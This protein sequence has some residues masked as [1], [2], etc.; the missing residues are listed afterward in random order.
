MKPL[1]FWVYK[2][3]MEMNKLKLLIV[4]ALFVL[5]NIVDAQ[6]QSG[7]VLDDDFYGSNRG[8]ASYV[9]YRNSFNN[10]YGSN[11]NTYWPMMAGENRCDLRQDIMIQVSPIGCQPAV[12]R[13]DLLAE[14][15]VP[16][17]CQ[18]DLLQLNPAIDVKQIKSMSFSGKYPPYV[19][20]VGFHPARAALRTRGSL[21]GSPIESN[22]GYVVVILKQNQ[23]ETAL[24]DFFNFT[25]S[26]TIDY[27]S[28]NALG[29]GATELLIEESSEEEWSTKKYSQSFL[30]GRYSVRLINSDPNG[31]RIGLYEGDIKTSELS[32]LRDKGRT[33]NIYLPNSYCQTELK[34]SYDEFTSSG[35]IIKM[36]IDDD[37]LDLYEGARFLNGQCIVRK[38]SKSG[39]NDIAEVSCGREILKL[40]IKMRQLNNGTE[41]YLDNKENKI[42]IIVST[43]T[44]GKTY[45]IRPLEKKDDSKEDKKIDISKITPV[46]KDAIY[47]KDYGDNNEYINGST[48]HYEDVTDTYGFEKGMAHKYNKYY[49]EI[50]LEEAIDLNDKNERKATASK[51]IDKYL[52]QYPEGEQTKNYRD[53]QNKYYMFDSSLSG[54]MIKT[55]DGVVHLVKILDIRDPAKLSSAK[56]VWGGQD[57]NLLLGN[58]APTKYGAI[59]LTSVRNQNNL[60][61]S[62]LCDSNVQDNKLNEPRVYESKMSLNLHEDK[63]V[64]GRNL[65]V[66]SVDLINSINL[67]INAETKTRTTS[68]FTV[69]IGIDKRLFQ[70]TPD[71]A[72]KKIEN[73]NKSIRKWESISNKLGEVVKGLK[74][75]CFVTALGLTAKNYFVGLSGEALA[76]REVM[77]GENGWTDICKKEVSEGTS[78]SLNICYNKHSDEIKKAVATRAKLIKETNDVIEEIEKRNKLQNREGFFAGDSL[79]DI[80]ARKDLITKIKSECQD[81]SVPSADNS[82]RKISD[83]LPKT[84]QIEN[85]EINRYD[86][87]QLRDIYFNCKVI[88]DGGSGDKSLQK[89]KTDI[90]IRVNQIDERI[91]LEK[92]FASHKKVEIY[93]LNNGIDGDYFG[94]TAGTL[95]KEGY[96]LGDLADD[97]PVQLIRGYKKM[98][99]VVLEKVSAEKYQTGKIYNL[100]SKSISGEYAGSTVP[101]ASSQ[102]DLRGLSNTF[103]LIVSGSYYNSFA[104]GEAKVKYFETE[105]YKGMPAI[106]PFDLNRGFYVA[107]TQNLPLLGNTK[108][109]ESNGRPSTFFVCNIMDDMKIGFYASKYGGDKCVQFN[110]YTGQSFG[111]FPGLTEEDT[112]KLVSEATRA[113]EEAAQQHGSKGSVVKIRG[114]DIPVGETAS[115]I[116]GTQCQ[117][118][119]SPEDCKILFNVCDPVICPA[120]RCNMGGT[121]Q[122]ADVVQSGIFGS[123]ALCLPNF[124]E[125]IYI[126]ICLTG[127]KAGIDG[128]LS[129]MKSHQACLQE[130]IETGKYVGICDQI[131]SVYT[132]EFFWRNAAPLVSTLLTKAVEYAYGGQGSVRGG[133]EYM[134]IQNSW[135]NA[136]DSVK[137]F[138]QSY[139]VNAMKAFNVRSLAEAGTPI[140][141]AF[142]SAKGPKTFESLIEP[143]SPSQFHAWFS[144]IDHTDV[145]VPATA[146][147]KV[148]YHIFSGNDRGVSY[149]VYLK[150]PPSSS[151]YSANPIMMVANGFISK[152]QYAT[153]SKDFTAPK[154]YK[155]L[156]VRIND[157]EEC[158]FK[159]VSSSFAINFVRDEIVQDELKASDIT[160][161][162]QCISGS[163][164]PLAAFN[165]NIQDAAQEAIDPAI[166]NRGIVRIC[167]T[168]NPGKGT[169]PT[170]FVDKGYCGDPALRCWLDKKSVRNA[171][172][173]SNIG[174]INKTLLEL[175]KSQKDILIH[176]DVLRYDEFATEL[177]LITDKIKTGLTKDKFD[178]IILDLNNLGKKV[179]LNRDRGTIAYWK[180]R[181]Y[182]EVFKT[183]LS[184]ILAD[185]SCVTVK[186]CALKYHG[187]EEDFLCTAGFC[188]SKE[189]LS[190]I[191]A[192]KVI[193]SETPKV[194][195]RFLQI[196]SVIDYELDKKYNYE[197]LLGGKSTRIFIDKGGN[198]VLL[199]VD[200][201]EIQDLGKLGHDGEYNL[202]DSGRDTFDR[203]F[204]SEGFSQIKE[205][206]SHE[207]LIKGYELAP[208]TTKS[209]KKTKTLKL[210][211]ENLFYNDRLIND[212]LYVKIDSSTGIGRIMRPDNS[213]D[214]IVGIIPNNLG[215]FLDIK[216]E[217]KDYIERI[218][219]KGS[220]DFLN[221]KGKKGDWF[222]LDELTNGIEIPVSEQVKILSLMWPISSDREEIYLVYDY[223]QT[224]VY[225]E[226]ESPSKGVIFAKRNFNVDLS[227]GTIDDLN[228]IVWRDDP[229]FGTGIREKINDLIGPSAYDFLNSKGEKKNKV[230][231]KDLE[232]GIEIPV[233]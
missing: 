102:D 109:F 15:S 145:T 97:T 227:L 214:E 194:S 170:R 175:E 27:Y 203:I 202:L 112:R 167:A 56:I 138:T 88:K 23:N 30:N 211:G 21:L 168:D 176:N 94:D 73:L 61:F 100:E 47:D 217:E 151:E 64:C 200:N 150:D 22:I 184:L 38:V 83:L 114:K 188:Q 36:Q 13:S 18:L 201:E 68:N 215:I 40:I 34:F 182:A 111:N 17:F 6:I 43:N 135:D 1:I 226:F 110:M 107:T 71:K 105:P 74:A 70:L 178:M 196:S 48:S 19:S 81:V 101:S 26:A 221:A 218:L 225:V 129:L 207:E 44:D 222:T 142:I 190:N 186:D 228:G 157:N 204:K 189:I 33:S 8:T 29:I 72:Q 143:D 106:V 108:S 224:D 144:A 220:Y 174:A 24:P 179:E 210:V 132:C 16:I 177:R 76:R 163:V 199:G 233:Q 231:L 118:F 55:N 197:F 42:Y 52:A 164:S 126:P 4:I 125:G 14:Q 58:S 117:D 232:K 153:E 7:P 3:S 63:I 51:L 166:Y 212:R 98:Y 160:T 2:W 208:V 82:N 104:P 20:T 86:Y 78:S 195:E 213:G 121:Y 77:Q 152:G 50:A 32:L 173:T 223:R 89:A 5:L 120:S 134:T 155:Q 49:G 95:K 35:K 57:Y 39:L 54:K 230:T 193:P 12:V 162:S 127:V 154:G 62:V 25:L 31:V 87:S 84:A 116:P 169:D 99:L 128:Y 69:G 90:E 41:V 192:P 139:A 53:Y 149:N 115:L 37:I 131:N 9:N 187:N 60:E 156:C 165:P 171:I 113:L 133:G 79:D 122:V 140:C 80:G 183:Q 67:R 28:G 91:K 191:E 65:R 124:K 219:G 146:Q 10:Y 45:T 172:T 229:I 59:T 11:L 130:A 85:E 137:Y 205:R 198:V 161:N 158:G 66:V 181:A 180:A 206:S 159:Q 119:M 93:V 216:K 147:Y 103:K 123:I 96:V 136:Q 209:Y 46:N 185:S 141:K 75:A 148:F 92:D